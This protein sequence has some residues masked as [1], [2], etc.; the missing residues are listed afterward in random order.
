[1]NTNH[2]ILKNSLLFFLISLNFSF[3]PKKEQNSLVLIY[4][5]VYF[6]KCNSEAFEHFRLEIVSSENYYKKQQQLEAEL[7]SDY[8]NAKKIRTNSSKFDYATAKSVCV[9]KWRSGSSK[10]SYDVASVIFGKTKAE[11]M[12]NAISH[13]NKWAGANVDY[14]ILKEESW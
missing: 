13:K 4:G 8:P 11:A 12:S 5:L 6:D 14:T 1:M 10:C 3:M 9:I 2:P 7:K